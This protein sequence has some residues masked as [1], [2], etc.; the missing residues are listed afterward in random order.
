M[1]EKKAYEIYENRGMED[2]KALDDWLQ[3]ERMV[4]GERKKG[5]KKK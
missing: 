4:R 2:G 3:A 5:R 1:V